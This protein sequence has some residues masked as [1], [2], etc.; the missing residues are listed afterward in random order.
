MRPVQKK[1]SRKECRICHKKSYYISRNGLCLDC[2]CEKVKLARCQIRSKE[3]VV[4]EKWKANLIKSLSKL[5]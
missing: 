3:G 2:V 5:Q 1:S 4:Y